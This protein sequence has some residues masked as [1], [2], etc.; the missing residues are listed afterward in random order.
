MYL[1]LD[2]TEEDESAAQAWITI[3]MRAEERYSV[4]FDALAFGNGCTPPIDRSQ[5][6]VNGGP[7]IGPSPNVNP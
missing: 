3:S 5:A 7:V 1:N 4:D 2:R 6:Y